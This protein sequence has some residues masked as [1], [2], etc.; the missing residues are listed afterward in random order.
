[1][2]RKQF[3]DFCKKEFE[4]HGFKKIKKY[5]YLA[6]KDVLCGMDLQKSNYGCFYYINYFYCIGD[7]NNSI[8]LPTYYDGDIAS[9]ICVMS[10]TQTYQGKHFMTSMVEY[11]EYTEDELRPYF[12]KEFKENI[13]PPISQGKKYIL[14]NLNKKYCL[15]LRVDEVL[16]KLQE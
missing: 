15:D 10:K 7:Y 11:E 2:E 1:M 12:D 8:V 3:I 16:R 13:L 6:G 14:E 5:F 9:R 4:K